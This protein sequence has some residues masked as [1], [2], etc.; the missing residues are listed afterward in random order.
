[1]TIDPDD[2]PQLATAREVL[3]R[4][5]LPDIG[6]GERPWRKIEALPKDLIVRLLASPEMR[7]DWIE[8][9]KDAGPEH[10]AFATLILAGEHAQAVDRAANL[11]APLFEGPERHPVSLL[12]RILPVVADGSPIDWALEWDKT[13]R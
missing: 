4:L 11:V 12:L 5:V 2:D 9:T 8:R 1:V 7:K 3:H 13:Q 6:P 10:I